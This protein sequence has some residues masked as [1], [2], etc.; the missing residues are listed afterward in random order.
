MGTGGF[1]IRNTS[2]GLPDAEGVIRGMQNPVSERIIAF[3]MMF[4]GMNFSLWYIAIFKRKRRQLWANT[5]FKIFLLIVILVT[6]GIRAN[7]VF[8]GSYPSIRDAL[9]YSFFHVTDIMSTT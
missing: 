2:I 9:R 3:F 1:S 5:E 8:Y 4:A 7:L 6:L